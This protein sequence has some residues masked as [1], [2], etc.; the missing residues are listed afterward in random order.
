MSF[1]ILSGQS[2]KR[3]GYG[4]TGGKF[5]LVLSSTQLILGNFLSVLPLAEEVHEV[6]KVTKLFFKKEKS[7]RSEV[8]AKRSCEERSNLRNEAINQKK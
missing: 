2:P 4:M 3:F 1:S 6:S 7:K 8:V 5:P